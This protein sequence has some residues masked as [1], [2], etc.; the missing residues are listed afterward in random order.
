[1]VIMLA[2]RAWRGLLH[3]YRRLAGDFN[4]I[5]I[6]RAAGLTDLDRQAGDDVAGF[7]WV[8]TGAEIGK[9]NDDALDPLFAGHADRIDAH[10]C[11]LGLVPEVEVHRADPA[12]H[13]QIE[14]QDQVV[15]VGE[16]AAVL[17]QEDL[18]LAALA[19]EWLAFEAEAIARPF[20]ARHHLAGGDDG[21][22]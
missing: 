7:R 18:P 3:R 14:D 11:L 17:L 13:P 15:R 4:V 19:R 12:I 22:L 6:E 16:E 10:A 9:A 21:R 5:D 20:R 8:V 2:S 1:M